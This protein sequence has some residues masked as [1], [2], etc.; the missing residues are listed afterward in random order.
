MS[1]HAELAEVSS[2]DNTDQQLRTPNK[3]SKFQLMCKAHRP[4]PL[5][6]PPPSWLLHK[7]ELWITLYIFSILW[8][9][10][11]NCLLYFEMEKIMKKS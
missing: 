2:L 7:L 4:P 9:L 3:K 6:L 5:H 1:T 10:M 8:E 11:K